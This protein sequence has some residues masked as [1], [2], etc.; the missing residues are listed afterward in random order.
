[1]SQTT[2]L[3][4][5][6][7]RDI[8]D[9]ICPVL[10]SHGYLV[11]EAED[12]IAAL[13]AAR[14]FQGFIDVLITDIQMPRLDGLELRAQVQRERPGTR[15]LFISGLAALPQGVPGEFLAKPFTPL[16]LERKIGHL[17][18]SYPAN[19]SAAR[20]LTPFDEPIAC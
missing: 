3:F 9:L 1:M 8:R 7:S 5:D 20:V 11:I 2:I 13:A 17:M 12:G 18:G 19:K 4:V 10:R 14:E 16:A 6:D 15:V